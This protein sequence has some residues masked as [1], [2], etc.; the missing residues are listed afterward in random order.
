MTAE[1]RVQGV[2]AHAAPEP[3][4][5]K[6]GRWVFLAIQLM[7]LAWMISGIYGGQ[8]TDCNGLS[9]EDCASAKG[10]GTTLGVG[11]IVFFWAAFDIIYG[12]TFL[13][14]RAVRRH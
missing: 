10:L 11:L 5:H 7:F 12:L 4:R 6:W 1:P 2:P 14:V 8:H 13:F 9:A 3:K